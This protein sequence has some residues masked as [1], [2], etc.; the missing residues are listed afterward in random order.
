MKIRA[1][2]IEDVSIDKS[3]MKDDK[4][5]VSKVVLIEECPKHAPNGKSLV[6]K[7]VSNKPALLS[8]LI[9]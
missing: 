6:S 8:S 5:V 9:L 1:S 3:A 7:L 4:M 2:V